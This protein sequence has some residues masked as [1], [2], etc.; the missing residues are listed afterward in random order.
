VLRLPRVFFDHHPVGAIL[1]RLTT[2]T[3]S[4][5]ES[6]S[7]GMVGVLTD[8]LKITALLL[9][10]FHIAG[11][12]TLVL[13]AVLVPS[14]FLIRWVQIKLRAI[15]LSARAAL[16]ESTGFLQE[17]L[18]GV[19][20]LQLYTAEARA[21][22]RYAQK[23]HRYY[24]AQ[25]LANFAEVSVASGVEGLTNFA[26]VLILWA[27][28]KGIA[29]GSVTV[30]VLIAFMNSVDRA[31]APIRDFAGHLT[32]L[33][34][35]F[36]ALEHMDQTYAVPSEP[37]HGQADPGDAFRELSF[38][39]VRFRYR[40]QGPDV[41]DGISFTLRKGQRIAIVGPTGSGKSTII[42]LLGKMYEGYEGSIRLNGAELAQVAP[43]RV[44]RRIAIMTQDAHLFEETVAFNIGLDRHGIG[45]DDIVS[46]A[47]YVYADSFIGRLPGQYDFHVAENGKNLSSGQGQL[48]CFARAVA[49][50]GEFVILDEAT[51]AVDS[52]TEQ[53]LEKAV[54]HVLR[55]KTVIAIAHRLST[56]R[57]ADLILVLDQG[58]IVERGTH[59]E[60]VRLG[61]L[62]AKLAK[63][64]EQAARQGPPVP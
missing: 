62:Y 23:N 25:R 55:D 42:R 34:K 58:R 27:G 56:I 37:R 59:E 2:D 50:A 20:T 12:L 10:L 51:S 15:Y 64:L 49:G 29:A 45:A 52:V 36:A 3:D 16:A 44:R 46:A 8:V 41:L 19:K 63:D 18:K 48:L 31:F 26:L 13:L 40:K 11:S 43:P 53:C 60:L 54:E 47:H 5:G 24:N 6:L 35:S 22:E 61:G 4:I 39:N 17:C 1:T 57:N 21:A 30:G 28:A 9:F 33:Q 7:V 38:E 32:V 14:F